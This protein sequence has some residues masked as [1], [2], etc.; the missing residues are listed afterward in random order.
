MPCEHG[1]TCDA[2]EAGGRHRRREVVEAV[3]VLEKLRC[4][5]PRV[6][7]EEVPRHAFDLERREVERGEDER[8]LGAAHVARDTD[9]KVLMPVVRHAV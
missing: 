3:D 7:R 1:E 8:A 9:A 5:R 4:E 6:V 2:V